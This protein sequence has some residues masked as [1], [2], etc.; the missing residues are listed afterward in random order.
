MDVKTIEDI[1][2]ESMK[3]HVFYMD[4]Q[5]IGNETFEDRSAEDVDEVG[6]NSQEDE[7]ETV[8]EQDEVT[9]ERD[10]LTQINSSIMKRRRQPSEIVTDKDEVDVPS[11]EESKKLN[12]DAYNLDEE[13]IFI[14]EGLDAQRRQKDHKENKIPRLSSDVDFASYLDKKTMIEDFVP[15]LKS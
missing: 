2:K 8:F 14:P 4:S 7:G 1:K 12:K 5:G 11:V 3:V 15:A 9:I 13:P 10:K 6:D